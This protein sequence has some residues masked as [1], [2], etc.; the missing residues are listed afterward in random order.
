M[1][2]RENKDWEK[3]N[4]YQKMAV[5]D[6]SPACV[7]NANVG[8]G[9]TTV[10]IAKVLYLYLEKKVPLEDMLVL[11]F[12]NKAAQ[13]ILSRLL[14]REPE[15]S[16]EQRA[17][18]GTFHSVALRLLKEKL[19]VKKAGWDR[20][21]SVMEPEE[22]T[23][24]AQ[25]IIK[26]EKLNIKYKNRLK[27]RLEQEY[28]AYLEGREASRYGDDL[29]R[30]YPLLKQEKQRENK[31]SFSDLLLVSTELIKEEG[32][33]PA[34]VIAD[35]IQDS[36]NLQLEFLEALVGEETRL[37]AV[38]DPNQVIYSWRGSSDSTF[39]VLKRRF[40]AKE[41]SLPVNYRSNARILEAANHF[42]QF[43]TR[44]QGCREEGKLIKVKRQYDPFT[45]AEYLA[46][47]IESLH[48]AGESYEDTAILYR[49][50]R[51]GELLEKVFEKRGIPYQVSVKQTV[52][53]IPALDWVVKILRFSVNPRDRQTGEDVLLNPGFGEKLTKKK[54]RDL[55]EEGKGK[56]FLYAQMKD[57]QDWSL[58]H[59]KIP[60]WREIFDYFGLG[61]AFG[62]TSAGYK[63][64]EEQAGKLLEWL[65][66]YC[67]KKELP[68]WEGTRAFL[69]DG[70]LYGMDL[71]EI[72]GE[73]EE[74]L[75]G[76]RLMTL[77]A[78]KGLEFHRVYL[79]GMNQGLIPLRCKTM[80]QEEEERRLF[81]VGMT[82]AKEELELS[83]YVNPREPGVFGEGS[84]YLLGIPPELLDWEEDIRKGRGEE[85]LRKL[86]RE[87]REELR[88]KKEAEKVAPGPRVCH[89]KYGEGILLSQ[90][91][92]TVEVEFS[93]YG[94]KQ[95]LKALGEIEV[96]SQETGET[97]GK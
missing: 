4:E 78:S 24:L 49:L 3:L 27:K 88:K 29:F 17:G 85:N 63:E 66:V 53:D 96:L 67:E 30:L 74:S 75:K 76:V 14:L 57:F 40:S 93:G 26:E 70:A 84:R 47:Q 1:E 36:D 33:H 50:Q 79:I 82:R 18:F 7:V 48:K 56:S 21:F 72:M 2:T 31:M 94:R 81:F 64:R 69:N 43:G 52:K 15:L 13:E 42:R 34:W 51:Q 20:D 28:K 90:N 95:F 97:Y 10:L 68:L 73:R 23:E 60:K 92:L 59:T 62:P 83:Y 12:T 54:V 32:F 87:V 65:R 37:F 86:G 58:G 55:L 71:G 77:H 39:F 38:G 8:S 45:E 35:E 80:E 89:R 25:R 11:T 9:K 16:P 41:L 6:D 19:S 5:L 22:E 91:E 61:E 46:E 44:I